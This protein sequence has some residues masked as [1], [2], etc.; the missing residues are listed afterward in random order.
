[1][2]VSLCTKYVGV[3]K[4]AA[5]AVIYIHG[6][7]TTNRRLATVKVPA[8]GNFEGIRPTQNATG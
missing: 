3:S 5:A 1:M 4:L 8:T 7:A 6:I 2:E